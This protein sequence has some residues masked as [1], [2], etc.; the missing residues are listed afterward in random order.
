MSTNIFDR[1]GLGAIYSLSYLFDNTNFLS[2]NTSQSGSGYLDKPAGFLYTIIDISF[3]TPIYLDKITYNLIQMQTG[4]LKYDINYGK[5]TGSLYS[6]I[7]FNNIKVTRIKILWDLT[8]DG[9]SYKTMTFGSFAVFGFKGRY[10]LEI[11]NKLYTVKS[12]KITLVSSTTDVPIAILQNNIMEISDLNKPV[13]KT[14][15]NK[16]TNK[17]KIIALGDA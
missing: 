13:V 5:L 17:Y 16:L 4:I 1:P 15:L 14:E 6:G 9:Y 3:S 12:D 8:K 2:Q 11:D 10:L 7:S